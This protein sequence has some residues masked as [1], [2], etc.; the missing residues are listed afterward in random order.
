MLVASA[1]LPPS[2]AECTAKIETLTTSLADARAANDQERIDGLEEAMRKTQEECAGSDL[3]AEQEKRVA[4]R[5]AEVEEEK[6]NLL[7]A[8]RAGDIDDIE[9]AKSDLAE[10]EWELKEAERALQP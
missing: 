3:Q 10:A 2:A 9:D 8:E 6:R 5:R 7:E 1:V 4:E